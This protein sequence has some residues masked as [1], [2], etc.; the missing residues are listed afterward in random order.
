MQIVEGFRVLR[1]KYREDSKTG[2]DVFFKPHT[3]RNDDD[4]KPSD[5]TIFA[6]NIPPWAT[7]ES[8]K[9][10]FQPNGPVEAVY[11]QHEPSVGSPP[12]PSDPLFPDPN[13]PY[14]LGYA[15]RYAYIVFD[16]PS[17]QSNAMTKMDVS[18][19]RVCSTEE[20]PIVLGVKRWCREYN[21]R[22]VKEEV[23][24]GNIDK[25]MAEYDTKIEQEKEEA[26]ELSKPDDDGWVTVN[27]AAKKPPA[28]AKKRTR[29]ESQ[30]KQRGEEEK[31]DGNEEFLRIPNER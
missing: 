22:L 28:Q 3:V 11:F 13:D 27:R 18:E 23:L 9:R 26:E 20:H 25:Y 2:H 19:P 30:E 29:A 6:A 4:K 14:K 31:E 16:K 15:F 17:G 24:Q 8:I 10:I 7:T 1:V 12:D 21:E 5:R